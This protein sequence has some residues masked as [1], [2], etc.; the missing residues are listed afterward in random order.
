MVN[1]P[2]LFIPYIRVEYAR[3]TFDAIKRGKPKKLYFF[4]DK[5]NVL[6]KSTGIANCIR[7]SEKKKK[8]YMLQ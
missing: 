6:I 1:T 3:K 7:N 4:S 5:A 2:I 8:I